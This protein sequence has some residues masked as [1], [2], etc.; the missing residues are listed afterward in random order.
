M[1]QVL[2]ELETLFGSLSQDPEIPEF[3]GTKMEENNAA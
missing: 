2:T 3:R 1:N